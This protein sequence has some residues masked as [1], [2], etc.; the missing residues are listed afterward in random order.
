MVYIGDDL[1]DRDAVEF[2]GLGCCP[3][4]ACGSVKAVADYVTNAKGGEGVIREV[5]EMIL[6]EGK[7]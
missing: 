3:A 5:T 4:D 7:K 1:A 2:V 6:E